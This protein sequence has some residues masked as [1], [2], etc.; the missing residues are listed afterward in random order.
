MY[1]SL[2]TRLEPDEDRRRA[3]YYEAEDEDC[4][5]LREYAWEDEMLERADQPTDYFEE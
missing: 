3:Q 5:R 2:T 4:D 1:D